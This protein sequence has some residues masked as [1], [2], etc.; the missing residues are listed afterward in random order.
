[1]MERGFQSRSRSPGKRTSTADS[2]FVSQDGTVLSNLEAAQLLALG[3]SPA[4]LRLT[5]VP[6]RRAFDASLLGVYE[7]VVDDTARA[8]A[9]PDHGPLKNITNKN[10]NGLDGFGGAA[11]KGPKE[12]FGRQL[13]EPVRVPAF[14]PDRNHQTEVLRNASLR[15]TAAGGG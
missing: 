5:E 2:T 4:D 10:G 1:M 7:D 6:P 13:T 3:V 15:R 9:A 14:E 12:R 8:Q 11:S